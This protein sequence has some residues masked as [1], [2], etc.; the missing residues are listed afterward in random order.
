[1]RTIGLLDGRDR[2]VFAIPTI[3]SSSRLLP[4]RN[5][6]RTQGQH[7]GGDS[8]ASTYPMPI[9]IPSYARQQDPMPGSKTFASVR[10]S[11]ADI[12]L[13]FSAKHAPASTADVSYRTNPRGTG[14][15][16]RTPSLAAVGQAYI[17]T[18]PSLRPGS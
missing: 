18:A 15:R 16:A 12:A 2:H 4:G 5:S 8:C 11:A 17:G 1:V 3:D 14:N 9:A 10:S 13:G 7:A 6:P